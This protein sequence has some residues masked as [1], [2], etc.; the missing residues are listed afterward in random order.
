MPWPEGLDDCDFL[1][2]TCALN[3]LNR[4]MFNNNIIERCKTG[5][6]LINVARGPLIGEFA[7]L[8]GL[9]NGK[10][11][12]AALDVLKVNPYQ[13]PVLCGR[14]TGVY[15]GLTMDLILKKL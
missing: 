15:L 3:N 9:E 13:Y 6:R 5:I 11:Y 7:L 14:T 2:F 4:H 10:I 1:I 12:S 8:R